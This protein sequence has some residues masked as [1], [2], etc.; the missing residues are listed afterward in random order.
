MNKDL[1]QKIYQ[2]ISNYESIDLNYPIISEKILELS[3]KERKF[4]FLYSLYEY[5]SHASHP[6]KKKI[7]FENYI[8]FYKFDYEWMK[9][10]YLYIYELYLNKIYSPL[11]VDLLT[12]IMD[13]CFHI[14]PLWTK[15]IYEIYKKYKHKLIFSEAVLLSSNGSTSSEL[16]S[17]PWGPNFNILKDSIWNMIHKR[18]IGISDRKYWISEITNNKT[19]IS[20][21]II[22]EGKRISLGYD[23][24]DIKELY[25]SIWITN[26]TVLNKI[27]SNDDLMS[28]IKNNNIRISLTSSD[29]SMYNFSVLNDYGIPWT[30]QMR[31]W[32]EGTTFYTCKYGLKH[33][34]ENLFYCTEDK[35][36][37]DLLNFKNSWWREN[38]PDDIWIQNEEWKRCKCGQWY[39]NLNFRPHAVKWFVDKYGNQSEFLPENILNF[40]KDYEYVQIIQQSNKR[41]F[42]IHSNKD[43]KEEE[44]FR[45]KNLIR[46]LYRSSDFNMIFKKE[47]YKIG[48]NKYPV[49]YSCYEK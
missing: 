47:I 15:D 8:D 28:Y 23:F 19:V 49:F 29:S 14:S 16:V 24:R 21:F 41:D 40:I 27:S 13:I 48:R 17:Y 1:Y 5:L 38:N 22:N 9:F 7:V 11:R 39:R 32:K 34:L 12:H 26:C 35:K 10:V 30:D 25:D 18:T 44:I 42:Y 33:W 46:K 37:I 4:F 20:D 31:S 6:V 43:L 2:K 36:I 3:L 45:L